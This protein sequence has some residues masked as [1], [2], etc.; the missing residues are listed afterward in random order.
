MEDLPENAATTPEPTKNV[1]PVE[2]G[3]VLAHVMH[4]LA[5]LMQELSARR[6]FDA[7]F[8]R[9]LKETGRVADFEAYRKK[10]T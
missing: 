10:Q 3:N 9:W 4:E 1:P 5:D 2:P 8:G 7:E 6:R